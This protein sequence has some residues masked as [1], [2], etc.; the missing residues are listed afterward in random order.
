MYFLFFTRL[1]ARFMLL[2]ALF[3]LA[4]P[5]VY[6]QTEEQLFNRLDSLLQ[7][8]H[9]IADRKMA[10]IAEWRREQPSAGSGEAGM[11]AFNDRMYEEYK[12]FRYD[13]AYK[14]VNRNISLARRLGDSHRYNVS[15]MKLVHI[16]SVA[17]LFDQ[18]EKQMSA[19]DTLT[20]T[21]EDRITYYQHYCDLYL[22]NS[23]FTTGTDFFDGNLE[24]TQQFRAAIIRE[25][26][27]QSLL[28]MS[29]KA[30][31]TAEFGKVR[32][33]VDMLTAYLHRSHLRS[34]NRDYSI[35]TSMIA[36]FYYKLDE[37]AN[38]KRYLLL[39][40]ISDVQ[41]VVMENNSL[42]ELSSMLFDEGDYDRAYRYLNRSIED[43]TFY[44]TRLRNI[45]A[46]QL[47]PKVAEAYHA[48]KTR[49]THIMYGLLALLGVAVV[50]LI[51]ALV[52]T[53][54]YLHRYRQASRQVSQMNLQ[55]ADTVDQLRLSNRL[56][57]EGRGIREQYI[58]RFLDLSSTMIDRAEEY[59]RQANRLARDSNMKELYALLKGNDFLDENKSLF[60]ENFDTAFLNIYVDF[61][62]KVNLLLEPDGRI[63]P[64]DERLST[65]LRILALIRLGITETQK[66]ASI[67][68]SSISTI[69]TYRSKLKARAISKDDFERQVAE[70]D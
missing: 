61:V 44:G 60:Y 21:G 3:W 14:Y 9:E 23:E 70:I 6:A 38:R 40:A 27:P 15:V 42:R 67:L 18:A 16:L 37:P 49:Q 12:A 4:C 62:E 1:T 41:G 7:V 13:S 68:R 64:K 28:M 39:S 56:L 66:I 11:Y 17:G 54:H 20:L 43:A 24:R 22:F 55:L 48:S 19:I 52:F 5:S 63:Y 51:V 2:F 29:Y 45:Q 32:E 59:R 69:Y 65:E 31:Y 8:S 30:S 25:A 34:G 33:A 50:F 36:Y 53:R 10:R 46:S 58:G 47:I 57:E 35:L 26:P